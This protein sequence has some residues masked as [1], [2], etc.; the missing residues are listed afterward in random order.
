MGLNGGSSVGIGEKRNPFTHI[1]AIAIEEQDAFRFIAGLDFIGLN[2]FT[3]LTIWPQGVLLGAQRSE[4]MDIRQR[5]DNLR[6]L[7]VSEDAN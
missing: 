5:L 1:F 7:R 3:K 4:G 2:V 6:K